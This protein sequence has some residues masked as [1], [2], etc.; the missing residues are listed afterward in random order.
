MDSSL[1][2]P[3]CTEYSKSARASCK[4]CKNQISKEVLR[5]GVM[6]QSRFMDKKVPNWYH[7]NCFF[8]KQRPK[9]VGDIAG[10]ENLRWEDQK[11]IKD[12]V[13]ASDAGP[14]SAGTSKKR[15]GAVPQHLKD[16]VLEYAKSSRS[17]CRGCET[18]IAKG[19][20]RISKKDYES[21]SALM[22]GP[23][24]R[25]H[26]TECFAKK[27]DELEF[28]DSGKNLPGFMT[29]SAEDQKAV[30]DA[31]PK[32]D[33]KGSD[34]VD[35]APKKQKVVPKTENESDDELK[36]TNGRGKG[37]KKGAAK[38]T[39]TRGNKTD[40]KAA[41]KDKLN[42]EVDAPDAKKMEK[43]LQKQNKEYFKFRD[44]LKDS[45]QKR[46]LTELLEYNNQD[47][48]VGA[49]AILDR[50]ADAMTFGVLARC[51]E[52]DGGQLVYNSGIGY[53][54]KGN[55]TEYTKCQNVTLEPKRFPFKVPPELAQEH[56]FL[57]SYKV[58][59]KKRLMNVTAV[60]KPKPVKEVSTKASEKKSASRWKSQASK[61]TVQLKGGGT[62]VDPESGLAD[63]A[64]VLEQGRNKYCTVL[65]LTDIQKGKNSYYKLQVL[66]SDAKHS[67]GHRYWVFRA[68]GRIGTTRGNDK[69][70]EFDSKEEAVEH[71]KTLFL[72]KTGNAW[73][74][75]NNFKKMPDMYVLM[76]IQYVEETG[77]QALMQPC[78]VESKLPVPVQNFIKMI[79]D[80]QGMKNVLLQFELD[81]EKMPLGKISRR[82]IQQ[83][84]SVL[85]EL[86]ELFKSN[87]PDIRFID[88]SNRFYTLVPHDF[89]VD[90]A[91]VIR[92]ED[93]I[94][95]K[96]EMLDSLMEIEIAYSMI[97]SA[98]THDPDVNVV[99]AHYKKLN[100]DISILERDSEEFSVIEKYLQNTHAETHS[101]YSL[102]IVDV[103]KIARK[104]EESRFKPFRKLPNRHLLWH[105]SRVT[106]FAGILS[107]GLRI[108]PPEAPVTGYMF[109]KGIYFAD[110]VSKSANYCATSKMN[111]KGV[112]LLCDV[113]LGNM[114]ERTDADYIEKLPAG[115]HSCKGVGMTQ[116]DP[117]EVSALGDIRVPFGKPVKIKQRSSLLYNEYI[118]YDPAQVNIKFL[119]VVDFKYKY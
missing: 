67:G 32:L 25:W 21:E 47:V 55:V 81:L 86:Q 77:T 59:P 100:T 116:P 112:L 60:P 7:D 92:S 115:K 1:E 85:T 96:V 36:E 31:L 35:S 101:Q 24:D 15:K 69:V 72:D 6:V 29:L 117:S 49:D 26:H 71:F 38:A 66:E 23:V 84:Y 42:G 87:G 40:A 13:D 41:V 91:P 53:Q 78:K 88:A 74:N 113:A 17:E 65:S 57:G 95:Q 103:F 79:F 111:S 16:F 97:G 51:E 75:R 110:M 64:H 119:I 63:V 105:G 61:V 82:Q 89:G 27:R 28:F 4:G 19:L 70:E 52:C 18:K 104:G 2:R 8:M 118:V 102:E 94:K 5:L 9:S 73:E 93:V 12:K 50:L 44:Q 106:N 76:D 98:D 45:L 56:S 68:W 83:A 99:D 108:A 11:K 37:G 107:Q 33:K 34:D 30:A 22:Y 48:P 3:Y 80:V 14:S 43:L 20:V 54:C 114:Y 39:K 90:N 62:L 10:F 46:E 109:G 58:A